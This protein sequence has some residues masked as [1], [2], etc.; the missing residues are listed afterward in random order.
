MRMMNVVDTCPTNNEHIDRG[1]N[2]TTDFVHCVWNGTTHTSSGG[3]MTVSGPTGA[4]FNLFECTFENTRTTGTYGGGVYVY[5]IQKAILMS[6]Y[7]KNSSSANYRGGVELQNISV[8]TLSHNC[9][10]E[11]CTAASDTGGLL[12]WKFN[13]SEGDGTNHSKYKTVFGCRFSNC[14]S[15]NADIG[16]LY[17]NTPP[18]GVGIQDCLFHNCTGKT[19]AAALFLISFGSVSTETKFIKYCLFHNNSVGTSLTYPGIDIHGWDNNYFQNTPCEWSYTT[20]TNTCYQNGTGN[21]NW[22]NSR[23]TPITQIVNDNH[24]NALDTYGCGIDEYWPCETV[25]WANQHP[26]IPGSTTIDF[27]ENGIYKSNEIY[28][29]SDVENDEQKCGKE[30]KPCQTLNIS[31]THFNSETLKQIILLS[32]INSESKYQNIHSLT[33]KSN[34]HDETHFELSLSGGSEC[35]FDN[36]QSLTFSTLILKSGQIISVLSF[37]LK[38]S[39]DSSTLKFLA[40]F[41]SFRKEINFECSVNVSSSH[42]V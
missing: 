18:S 17:I 12:L 40:D 30:S 10:F 29:E 8:I 23:T 33:I 37:L 2:T 34:T 6:C 9:Y 14:K 19:G 21:V 13:V 24:D 15:T 4:S 1:T 31:S 3:A 20:G 41:L 5:N 27:Y 42:E 35:C 32:N 16:G 39:K 38:F 7:F 36:T 28:I 11:N 22:L 25:E 26:L